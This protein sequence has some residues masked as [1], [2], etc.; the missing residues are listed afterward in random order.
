M[1]RAGG[2]RH[3]LRL[4]QREGRIGC[5]HGDDRS[6]DAAARTDGNRS[7]DADRRRRIGPLGCRGSRALLDGA[8]HDDGFSAGNTSVHG[9]ALMAGPASALLE[10]LV[11]REVSAI[12]GAATAFVDENGAEALWLAV[13]RFAVL[14]FAPSMHAGRALVSCRAA[15]ALR[16]AAGDAWV[17]W[18]VACARYAAESR[19]PWSEPPP[20]DPPAVAGEELSALDA[21]IE[22]KD[23][24]AAERWLASHLADAERELAARAGG[25]SAILLETARW[26]ESR[27]GEKGRFALLR[28]VVWKLVEERERDRS[29]P[30]H[31]LIAN[32]REARGGVDAAGRVLAALA[33][34]PEREAAP[35]VS[36]PP[37]Y[38]LG[39]DFG[40]TL[41]AHAYASRLSP[42]DSEVLLA[43]VCENLEHG[44]S[45]EEWSHA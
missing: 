16:E 30:L 25:E 1:C 35:A 19:P 41:I 37:P 5:R 11:E 29:A 9:D 45:Y 34:V 42:A 32:V 18:I 27:L 23:R 43:A 22:A 6:S 21:A 10:V 2:L 3:C 24:L 31:E 4:V 7:D 20:L 26:L 15:G 13:T 44:E 40:Q 14:A 33:A 39:R 12:D 17:P 28:T 36:L 8:T 38:R